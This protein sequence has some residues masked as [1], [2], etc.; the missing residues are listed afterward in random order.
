MSPEILNV[1]CAYYM[2]NRFQIPATLVESFS[3]SFFNKPG[4][5][6][7]LKKLSCTDLILFYRKP[8]E[9]RWINFFAE[10]PILRNFTVYKTRLAKIFFN[11]RFQFPSFD[12]ASDR[13]YLDDDRALK[14]KNLTNRKA[15]IV[16]EPDLNFFRFLFSAQMILIVSI[17]MISIVSV[18]YLV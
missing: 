15:E 1:L 9:Y 5:R 11:W 4:W 13:L 16:F 8:F 10:I 6:N 17:A 3:A 18:K 14:H 2:K 7:I 12:V